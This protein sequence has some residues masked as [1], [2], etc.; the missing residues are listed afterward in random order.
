LSEIACG[1]EKDY[2]YNVQF[3]FS[4]SGVFVVFLCI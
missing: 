3:C 1:E 4:L 2:E